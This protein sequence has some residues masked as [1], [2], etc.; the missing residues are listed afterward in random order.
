MSHISYKRARELESYDVILVGSGIGSLVTAAALSKEGK[1]CLILE[2]HYEPGGTL[3]PLSGKD[4][5][6]MLVYII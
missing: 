1:R 2:R 4:M 5:N 3:I 6:G